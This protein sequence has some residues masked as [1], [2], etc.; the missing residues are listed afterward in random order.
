[1]AQNIK[2]FSNSW[3]LLTA[4]N[5]W[6]KSILLLALGQFVPV[7]GPM[8][9]Y[10]YGLEWARESA[11]G[12]QR[13]FRTKDKDFSKIMRTGAFAWVF[14]IVF[15]IVM[16][17]LASALYFVLYWIPFIGWVLTMVVTVAMIAVSVFGMASTLRGAIYD[18]LAPSFQVHRTYDVV[19]RDWGGF[20]KIAAI[21]V[22]GG[23]IASVVATIVILPAFIVILVPIFASMDSSASNSAALA[24]SIVGSVG[25]IILLT[26]LAIF[27][28][29]IVL[30]ATTLIT[31]HALGTWIEQ[32]KPAVWGPYDQPIPTITY[33]TP[34][35]QTAPPAYAPPT[36]A[37][38][39][40]QAAPPAQ[41]APAAAPAE[42]VPPVDAQPQQHVEPAPAF[43][44]EEPAVIADPIEPA[45]PAAPEQPAQEEPASEEVIMDEPIRDDEVVSDLDKIDPEGFEPEDPA[46]G[47]LT[48]P[49]DEDAVMQPDVEEGE[50]D[51]PED[52][53]PADPAPGPET[54][55]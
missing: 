25:L 18:G 32:Y 9:M 30:V 14:L 28:S 1:M 45:A 38:A 22:I 31:Y 36:Q 52:G 27:I 21:Y 15:G 24:T 10:G 19:S 26:L 4:E 11:W 29:N 12:I 8:A 13:P 42:P 20:L 39:P 48:A 33:A 16:G 34:T 47:P 46:P 2:Y 50:K 17:T 53:E 23:I 55:N 40:A 7:A 6:I 35:Y 51:A 43:V 37:T 49:L 54:R 5:G 44:A 41:P 3:R